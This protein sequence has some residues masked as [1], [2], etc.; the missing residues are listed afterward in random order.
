[1]NCSMDRFLRFFVQFVF[2]NFC[3]FYD[4]RIFTVPGPHSFWKVSYIC[5]NGRAVFLGVRL[6]CQE[7]SCGLIL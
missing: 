6:P 5:L 4:F 7:L 3:A 1:M 2:S